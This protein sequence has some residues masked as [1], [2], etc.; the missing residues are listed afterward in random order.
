MARWSGCAIVLETA[1][2]LSAL[3]TPPRRT[4]RVI[5]YM[6]EENGLS[7][8]RAYAEAHKVELPRHAAAMEADAGAGRPLGF[9]VAGGPP[10]VALVRALAAPLASLHLEEVVGTDEAG[11]DLIPLQL[12]GVPVLGLNQD[13]T[14]YF[15][16]HHTAADTLDKIDPIDLSL[17]VAAFALMTHALAESPERLPPSPPPPRW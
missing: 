7:G 15:D 12:G 13:M 11:A 3:G 5:L 17:D 2:L 6:N 4:V 9:A 1:R 8:A 16:W 14:S 10:S